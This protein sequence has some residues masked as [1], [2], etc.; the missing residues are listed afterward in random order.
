MIE[1]NLDVLVGPTHLHGGLSYGNLASEQNRL[2]T[3]NPKKAALEGLEKMKLVYDLGCVQ[4]IFPPQV[5]PRLDFLMNVGFHGKIIEESFTYAPELLYQAASSSSM[6]AANAATVTSS[7]DSQDHKVHISI[8]N[9]A[10]N[11]HRSLEVDDTYT[12][13]KKAFPKF[14]IHPPLPSTPLFYDEGAANHTRFANGV[15][16]FVWGRSETSKRLPTLYPARQTLEAQVAIAR[17]HRL[18]PKKVVFAQ[19]NPHLIDQG[20][21]HN[22]VIATGHNNFF[23][24]HEESYS[25]TPHVIAELLQKS[26]LK[27]FVVS[28]KMLSIK[29]AVSSYLFNSQ[30]ITSGR[31]TI[32]ICPLEVKKTQ[33]ARKVAE[34]LPL[35]KILYI[36]INQSMKNGGG[37]ACLRLRLWLTKP[38]LQSVNSKVIFT[39]KLYTALKK[40]IQANY[41]EKISLSDLKDLSFRKR[42]AT[43]YQQIFKIMI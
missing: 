6:W 41:P 37:P 5:C 4:L 13:F 39:P 11:L 15:H 30:I 22:D 19:Q 7:S 43:C 16:L 27:V 10:S 26:P 24:L 1:A 18:D 8:A 31:Q 21:F 17:R 34:S 36:P 42:L 32:M 20:V 38:E 12:L 23:L 33:A 2:K 29:E 28:K 9:L 35:D 3:S 25:N 40:V 14:T